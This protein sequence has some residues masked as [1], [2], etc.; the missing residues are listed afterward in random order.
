[1]LRSAVKDVLV[2]PIYKRHREQN[3]IL[4]LMF[5]FESNAVT[6]RKTLFLRWQGPLRRVRGKKGKPDMAGLLAWSEILPRLR[7]WRGEKVDADNK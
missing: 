1:M 7:C 5:I 6:L 3:M 2:R 4:D